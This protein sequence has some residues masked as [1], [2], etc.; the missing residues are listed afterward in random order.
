MRLWRKFAVSKAGAE[1]ENELKMFWFSSSAR[2]YQLK[3]GGWCFVWMKA[4]Y[5]LQVSTYV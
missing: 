3:H 1:D 4:G 5:W 2:I